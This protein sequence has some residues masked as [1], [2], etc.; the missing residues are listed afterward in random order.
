MTTLGDVA[1]HWAPLVPELNVRDIASSLRF[2]CELLGFQILFERREEGFAYLEHEGAQ[3]MLEQLGPGSWSVGDLERPFGRGINLQIAT[4]SLSPMLSRLE[5]AQW[6][7][8]LPA[9]DRW[10]RTGA[11]ESGQRQFLVQDPDGYL[12]RFAEPLGE[13][14][15]SA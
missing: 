1:P 6:P 7:L 10:Y 3:V 5:A 4:S 9:T 2:W 14:P 13:R 15:V 12:L 8:Y 11:V